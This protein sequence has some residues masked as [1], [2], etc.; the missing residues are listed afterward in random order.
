VDLLV[1][2]P[3]PFAEAGK[4]WQHLCRLYDLASQRRLP[5]D[6]L[7]YSRD[8]VKRLGEHAGHIVGTVLQSGKRIY[9]RP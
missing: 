4:R 6:I 5:V 2:E 3:E 7:L 9:E 1:I 8:E